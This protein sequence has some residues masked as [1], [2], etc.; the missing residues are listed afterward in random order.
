M[1]PSGVFEP[2]LNCVLSAWDYTIS[3]VNPA[4]IPWVYIGEPCRANRSK[5]TQVDCVP[6]CTSTSQ[7]TRSYSLET[8]ARTY[9]PGC[10]PLES[11]RRGSRTGRV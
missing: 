7:K 9:M 5:K 11:V 4:Y 1:T 3:G 6:Q 8:L 2:T 10:V